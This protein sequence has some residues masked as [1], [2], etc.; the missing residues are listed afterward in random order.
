MTIQRLSQTLE[1]WVLNLKLNYGLLGV[2][3]TNSY[4]DTWLSLKNNYDH[5][6]GMLKKILN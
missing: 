2:R 6:L 4:A 3:I 5:R 1:K